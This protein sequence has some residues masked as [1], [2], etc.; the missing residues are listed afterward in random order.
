MLKTHLAV[1]GS[2]KTIARE[3][4]ARA[5]KSLAIRIFDG[6]E[7]Q[8]TPA[9]KWGLNLEMPQWVLDAHNKK[10]GRVFLMGTGPSLIGQI[11]ILKHL[12]REETWTVNRMRRFYESGGLPFAPTV[13]LVAEPG[14]I[15]D[16]GR[17]INPIYDFPEA[18]NRIAINWWPVTAKGWLWCP[19]APDD[20]QMRWEGCFGM[21]DIFP[22]IPTGWASPLTAL[23]LAAWMGYTEFYFLG[24]DTTQMG[25]AWDAERGRTGNE[26][27]I[28]SI[29][30]C[31]DAA[32]RTCKLHD[33]L[34]FDCS[35]GG[36]L[37]K[38]GVLEYRDLA[39]VLGVKE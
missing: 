11:P 9:D 4:M 18:T 17:I 28:R 35:T 19:K 14:P 25:Q 12:A 7:F 27:N 2:F 20:V 39:D 6:M 34:I 38:E 8:G 37:N 10:S 29:L 26:R 33:R 24:C 5:D 1:N 31:F 30:E 13:H 15:M 36:R 22:P 16:W 21:D 32:R 3:E 23:Q